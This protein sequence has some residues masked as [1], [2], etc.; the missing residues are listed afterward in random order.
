MLPAA[1]WAKDPAWTPK[2]WEASPSTE[3]QSHTHWF[4]SNNYSKNDFRFESS[5]GNPDTVEHWW[6]KTE[7][8]LLLVILEICVGMK[9]NIFENNSGFQDLS[10][11]STIIVENKNFKL[12]F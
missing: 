6:A 5:S 11:F 10:F 8:T 12:P 4:G 7:A 2:K 9:R 3:P 1:L